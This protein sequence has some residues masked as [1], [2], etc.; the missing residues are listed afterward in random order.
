[1]LPGGHG[2]F[3]AETENDL[4]FIVSGRWCQ[5]AGAKIAGEVGSQVLT[6]TQPGDEVVITAVGDAARHHKGHGGHCVSPRILP[7]AGVWHRRNRTRGGV[8][9]EN[10]ARIIPVLEKLVSPA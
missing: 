5:Y 9:D 3:V 8:F 6:F 2:L 1:M 4:E 7:S 10:A